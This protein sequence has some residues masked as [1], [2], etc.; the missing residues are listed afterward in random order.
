V[1]CSTSS[2]LLEGTADVTLEERL[3]LAASEAEAIIMPP[4]P[5]LIDGERALAGAQ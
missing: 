5:A 4:M 1:A 2:N 3:M